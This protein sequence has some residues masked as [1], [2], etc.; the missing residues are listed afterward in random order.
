MAPL[1]NKFAAF[2]GAT[3]ALTTFTNAHMIMKTPTPFGAST[4]NN[5][6]LNNVARGSANSD[7]PC[8]Q[9]S[10][11][12][13][14]TTMNTMAVGAPQVLSFSG[15][16]SHDGG[17]CQ[18]SVSLD[19]EPT[20]NSTF[21]VIQSY[22]GG[23]PTSSTSGGSSE[24]S[25]SIPEGMPDGVA[26]LAWTW[27]NKVGNRE[28]YMNCAPII[29]SGGAGDHALYDSLPDMFVINLPNMGP[30]GCATQDT[31]D[32]VFPDPG[33]FVKTIAKTAL[34][35]FSGSACPAATGGSGAPAA[36]GGASAPGVTTGSVS[37][38]LSA[39]G[40]M[41]ASSALVSP[42][43]L[44][45]ASGSAASPTLSSAS[46]AAAPYPY[47]SSHSASAGTLPSTRT[48]AAS[49][50]MPTAA[51]SGTATGRYANATGS[52][53][54]PSSASSKLYDTFAPSA[55]AGSSPRPPTASTGAGIGS[56][57]A[58]ATDGAVVCNGAAQF[59]ICD[60]G[61]LVWRPVAAGTTCRDGAVVRKRDV[62]GVNEGVDAVAKRFASGT[63]AAR[64]VGALRVFGTLVVA[65]AVVGWV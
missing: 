43:T 44:S 46:S 62:A 42:S 28:L 10:G 33:K 50:A 11:V 35:T 56:G 8:K 17:S 14:I 55:P 29:I 63:A 4:L 38:S 61:A 25:F 23:C 19:K 18:L 58:C 51:A 65:G 13:D 48:A 5:S 9:R 53:A 26:T 7:Y 37:A 64:G 32:V 21:K 6:P 39:Y 45:A 15:S 24:F 27:Y 59:A 2:A 30:D 31:A 54:A 34:G 52:P 40:S 22:I 41:A 3:V 16:A 36:G 49:L 1:V 60:H 47:P 12:Y 57:T 20:A